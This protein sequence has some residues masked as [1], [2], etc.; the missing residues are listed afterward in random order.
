[1]I[2]YACPAWNP[3]QQYLSDKLER[4]QRNA[5]RLFLSKDITYDERLSKLRWMHLKTRR[6]FLSLIQLF[7]YI[8]GF[9]IVNLDDYVKFSSCRTR[10]TNRSKIQL[11]KYIKGFCILNLDDYVKFSSYR[12]RCTNR[13]KI[14]EPYART[15]ILKY[16]FWHRY[17]DEWNSLPKDI[18]EAV[19][20]SNFKR[21]L[22]KMLIKD[23]VSH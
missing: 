15:N 18:V 12:T 14:W 9:C 17:N 1:M 23:S 6:N 8:K 10:C 19:S 22:Y 16:S 3:H 2:E 13:Y 4:I 21:R 5:S 7:K 20:V 11:F